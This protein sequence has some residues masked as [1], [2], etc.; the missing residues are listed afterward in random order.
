MHHCNTGFIRVLQRFAVVGQAHHGRHCEAVVCHRCTGQY[1]VRFVG[2]EYSFWLWQRN[3]NKV[4]MILDLTVV[5]DGVNTDT[6]LDQAPVVC[7]IW[8]RLSL[9]LSPKRAL[10]ENKLARKAHIYISKMGVR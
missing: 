7:V 2:L 5:A 3:A 10:V 4:I 8:A 1:L 9:Y 6:N